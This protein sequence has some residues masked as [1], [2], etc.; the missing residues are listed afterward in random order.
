[1]KKHT[2]YRILGI[3]LI[4]LPFFGLY[5]YMKDILYVAF[6]VTLLVTAVNR[7]GARTQSAPKKKETERV[8][9]VVTTAPPVRRDMGI[10]Q[11]M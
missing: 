2:L 8:S 11:P 10:N 6:G 7:S 1:M 5:Q 4:L 9:P 3:L